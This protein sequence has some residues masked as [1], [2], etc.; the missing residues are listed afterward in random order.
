MGKVFVVGIAGGSGSGKTTLTNEVAASLAPDVAVITHDSY[1]RAHHDM[2]YDERTQLNYDCPDSYETELLVQHLAILLQGEPVECPTYDFAIHDRTDQTVTIRPASVIVV[3]GI[4]LF[5][6]PALR[7]LMDL[8]V[9]VDASAD[10]RILRRLQ[11]D[12]RERGR[13]I[14][15]VIDQYLTTVRPMHE[16]YVEPSKRYADLIVPTDG[17]GNFG[18]AVRVLVD[19]IQARQ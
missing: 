19:R 10:V 5:E 15:S 4:L 3:E 14:E 12:V 18:E 6:N 2:T 1:Y 16:A 17:E 11:R 13:S 9:F 8:K 7:A